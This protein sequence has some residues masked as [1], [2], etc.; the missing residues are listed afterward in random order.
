MKNIFVNIIDT[1]RFTFI[2]LYKLIL[3]QTTSG[4]LKPISSFIVSVVHESSGILTK[5]SLNEAM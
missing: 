5:S 4:Y 1:I 3:L 2:F